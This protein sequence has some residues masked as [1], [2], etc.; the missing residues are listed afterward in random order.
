MA[1]RN[2]PK[3][4]TVKAVYT[5]LADMTAHVGNV[6]AQMDKK[7]QEFATAL[8]AYQIAHDHTLTRVSALEMDVAGIRSRER[9]TAAP[10]PGFGA[11]TGIGS[12]PSFCFPVSDSCDRFQPGDVLEKGRV[13][14]VLRVKE[15]PNTDSWRANQYLWS[16]FGGWRFN[17]LGAV[18]GGAHQVDNE[19]FRHYRDGKEVK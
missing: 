16:L 17:D 8:E 3:A 11:S 18:V 9:A 1:K 4:V 19:G 10:S 14:Y 7:V 5:M 2:K 13:R 6:Q 15:F 12:L